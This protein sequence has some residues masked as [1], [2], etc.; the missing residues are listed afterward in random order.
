MDKF[1]QGNIYTKKSQQDYKNY[2]RNISTEYP[3]FAIFTF[4][5]LFFL[6]KY[7]N[8]KQQTKYI[9][10]VICEMNKIV[11]VFENHGLIDQ[12]DV[13]VY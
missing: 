3:T 7:K 5:F 11:W 8:K 12:R 6:M 1:I 9:S 2:M 10:L 13:D 4:Q